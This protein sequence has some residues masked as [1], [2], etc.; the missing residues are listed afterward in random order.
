MILVLCFQVQCIPFLSF[1]V[2]TVKTQMFSVINFSLLNIIKTNEELLLTCFPF[3]LMVALQPCCCLETTTRFRCEAEKTRFKAEKT[4]IIRFKAD[5]RETIRYEADTT[6]TIRFKADTTETICFKADATETMRF[7]DGG[8]KYRFET[9]QV[10]AY[11][12]RRF[13]D[14]DTDER[15]KIC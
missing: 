3:F 5:T 6:E 2:S 10:R 4:E 13:A 7:R 8:N 14:D 11:Y 15:T 1:C 12:F 9:M